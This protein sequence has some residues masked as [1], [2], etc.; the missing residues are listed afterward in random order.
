MNK[1]PDISSFQYDK[2]ANGHIESNVNMYRGAICFQYN[3][4]E[5]SKHE[6]V[7]ISINA[8]YNSDIDKS[9]TKCNV[10]APTGILGLGW[11]LTYEKIEC[12]KADLGKSPECRNYR[13]TTGDNSGSG[14][15]LHLTGEKNGLLYFENEIYD[16]SQ[17]IYDCGRE[18]WTITDQSGVKHLYGGEN[19]LQYAVVSNGRYTDAACVISL[20]QSRSIKSWNLSRV[21]SP[22]GFTVNYEYHFVE[23]SVTGSEL[24]YTKAAYIKKISDA[25]GNA[26]EFVY[27][28]KLW[29]V[30]KLEP[31]E[32]DDPHKMEPDDS[33]DFYQSE[34][35]TKYL[36][37]IMVSHSSDHIYCLKFGYELKNY[38][39]TAP[40]TGATA[41][42]MLTSIQMITKQRAMPA[43]QFEYCSQAEGNPGALKR[44]LYPEGGS[45]GYVYGKRQ[46]LNMSDRTHIVS[47]SGFSEAAKTFFGGDYAV[48]LQRNSGKMV[49]S[50]FQWIGRWQKY[51]PEVSFQGIDP[52]TA[53]VYPF[54]YY[55]VITCLTPDHRKTKYLVLTKWRKVKGGWQASAVETV[56]SPK[57]EIISGDKWF[58]VH[59]T[60][61]DTWNDYYYDE[62]K[63]LWE[64]GNFPEAEGK[65]GYSRFLTASGNRLLCF[66][67][68]EAG[69]GRKNII[70]IYERSPL[71]VWTMLAEMQTPSITLQGGG[72]GDCYLAFDGWFVAGAF[73]KDKTKKT[74]RYTLGVWRYNGDGTFGND[75]L[76]ELSLPVG[77]TSYI[78]PRISGNTVISSG[79]LYRFCGDEWIGCNKLAI[80]SSGSF[81][82]ALA[83]DIALA[84]SVTESTEKIS[85]AV[86]HKKRKIWETRTLFS[87]KTSE[88]PSYGVSISSNIAVCGS[89]VYDIGMHTFDKIIDKLNQDYGTT[90]LFNNGT[91]I[92]DSV[93][94]QSEDDKYMPYKTYI[95]TIENGK[96]V[97]KAFDSRVFDENC[98][99]SGNIFSLS[100]SGSDMKLLF[101]GGGCPDKPVTFYQ[102]TGVRLDDGIDMISRNYRY[103]ASSA[104]CDESGQYARYSK[105]EVMNGEWEEKNRTVYRYL[106]SISSVSASTNVVKSS[107]ADGT[108]VSVDSYLDGRLDNRL[109]AE[110][111]FADMVDGRK[112][113]GSVLLGGMLTQ[114][115]E[116]GETG[117]GISRIT[118]FK[119]D[120]LSGER[121]E[122]IT[123]NYNIKGEKEE[124]KSIT[125]FA[126]E[127]YPEMKEQHRLAEV[128]ESIRTVNGEIVSD[129]KTEYGDIDGIFSKKSLTLINPASGSN[130]ELYH[131]TDRGKY[132]VVTAKESI[133]PEY[134]IFDR[135]GCCRVAEF[136]NC[137]F[138]E[139][140]AYSFE[141]YEKPLY[142][143][144]SGAELTNTI[145]FAGS[146]CLEVQAGE[147]SNP[148]WHRFTS[149]G[150]AYGF[151]FHAQCERDCRL[152]VSAKGKT[153]EKR[154]EAGAFGYRLV[155]LREFAFAKGENTEITF[156]FVNDTDAPLF[157]DIVSFFP[158]LNPPHINVYYD[159]GV[160]L[161]AS[162]SGYGDITE[163]VY[164]EI[165]RTVYLIGNKKVMDAKLPSFLRET[166]DKVNSQFTLKNAGDGQYIR[167]IA[168]G[169][170]LRPSL[171]LTENFCVLFSCGGDMNIHIGRELRIKREGN[172]WTLDDMQ[173]G[174]YESLSCEGNLVAVLVSEIVVLAVNGRV[175]FSYCQSRK[176][177]ADFEM[178]ASA[179]IL[180]FV[181]GN[182]PTGGI[183]FS[184]GAGK[185]RQE[186]RLADGR[187]CVTAKS[188]DNMGREM[189]VTI[190]TYIEGSYFR[191]ISGYIEKMD[192]V[193]GKMSGIVSDKNQDCKGYPYYSRLYEERSGGRVIETGSPC[194]EYAVNYDIDRKQ[195]HTV[196][197]SYLN[198]KEVPYVASLNDLPPYY[199]AMLVCDPDNNR[200]LTVYDLQKNKVAVAVEVDGRWLLTTYYEEYQRGIRTVIVTLPKGNVKKYRYDFAGNLMDTSDVNSGEKKYF[201][202]DYNNLRFIREEV[203]DKSGLCK[204]RMYDA[205]QRLTEE[206]LCPSMPD[207]AL[208]KKA[209]EPSFPDSG[210]LIGKRYY[211]D[212]D[213]GINEIGTLTRI[214]IFD[215]TKQNLVVSTI[216]VLADKS[217][218]SVTK[219]I[220]M[221]SENYETEI[222]HD[223]FGN[224]T[225]ETGTDGIVTSYSYDCASRVKT[226]LRNG[227]ILSET[228]YR[229]DGLPDSVTSC[230]N[231]VH[232]EYDGR[233]KVVG[234]DS[235]FYTEKVVYLENGHYYNGKIKSVE[236]TIKSG[237]NTDG[238]ANIRYDLTYDESGRLLSAICEEHPEFSLKDIRYDR[239][240]NILSCDAGGTV[241]TFSLKDGT[242]Q[243]V[244]DGNAKY[245]YDGNGTVTHIAKGDEAAVGME[246][247]KYSGLLK[248]YTI[249][250]TKTKLLYDENNRRLGKIVSKNGKV[251]YSKT[252]LYDGVKLSEEIRDGK[253]LKYIHGKTGLNVVS[254]RGV[255]Y[256]VITDRLGYT[257]VVAECEK[258]IEAYHYKPF[259][260]AVKVIGDSELVKILFGNYELD[261][262]TGLYYAK[263]RIYDP[264]SYR[265]LSIDPEGEFPS[266][267]TFCGNDPFAVIDE[268]GERSWY[269]AL[270]GTV[271]G[272]VLTIGLSVLTMGAAAPVAT[273]IFGA[274]ATTITAASTAS[275]T[276]AIVAYNVAMTFAVTAISG[277]ASE[278]VKSLID[279]E[280]FTAA[281]VYDTLLSAAVAGLVFGGAGTLVGGVGKF[282]IGETE[283]GL[284]VAKKY[285]AQGAIL[286]LTNA[287]MS[288][289]VSPVSDVINGERVSGIGILE[290]GAF[291]ALSG[292]I[293]TFATA[294]AE[295]KT[296]NIK[297]DIVKET[298][299]DTIWAGFDPGVYYNVAME[300]A[301]SASAEHVY[302]EYSVGT[303]TYVQA[304]GTS[305]A[306]PLKS[307]QIVYEYACFGSYGENSG[308]SG[309]G[310]NNYPYQNI[311]SP[312]YF[313]TRGFGGKL[314]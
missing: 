118:S 129:E 97:G 302:D 121:R 278:G 70:K 261:S 115:S 31:R 104:A 22:G 81:Q 185:L 262:E 264:Y 24:T 5:L 267:Y 25:Y 120:P 109:T 276:A 127:D 173:N 186:H 205:L 252:Y 303:K 298:V 171:E 114:V 214:E 165:G 230:G 135:T 138:G 63:E 266:P 313:V 148:I 177:E 279:G 6:N 119:A 248:Q 235:P 295:S 188:Y 289:A 49:F 291:G 157:I 36:S 1:S 246:Y 285:V 14:A 55:C 194:P 183:T 73:V 147:C 167:R 56:N 92:A 155:D 15:P 10:E 66:A 132:G 94:R 133:F 137:G 190:P 82:F 34:Y 284:A 76:E 257:R 229:A 290:N 128:C 258:I 153:A 274:G 311:I 160:L 299:N 164:D 13:L 260:E 95:H 39:N 29:C 136:T 201:Y 232:Y 193:T 126:Y 213:Y 85:A 100:K 130:K 293:T 21:I 117:E 65:N 215:E 191:Y 158:L 281:C 226:V 59:D 48:V 144:A 211:Y 146:K 67:Y 37:E 225:G 145:C 180:N 151:S 74:L 64:A 79:Y 176:N 110:Y 77:E 306:I 72:D 197:T 282:A 123:Y 80:K 89:T 166:G 312:R 159:G 124:Q 17:I 140:F 259:G 30:N 116:M 219:T 272:I 57:V 263:S 143:P 222:C 42:R 187:V 210:K 44:T 26:A 103:D 139:C 255:D 228:K 216:S 170:N 189:A 256:S 206:G 93:Y 268:N 199:T 212:G 249:G 86:F 90:R 87:G 202:D 175:L 9:L 75:I 61:G 101:A 236:T 243:L 84:S 195:R 251:Q 288:A 107:V 69:G 99:G 71:A 149:S 3:L 46:D 28:D 50:V 16:G 88:I 238:P 51:T 154:I 27:G 203:C 152:L 41:K 19:N 265:F 224:I 52:G 40:V 297:K 198:L 142:I 307:E 45:A 292:M 106:D 12:E 280:P 209:L 242:D 2:A 309:F 150:I 96:V 182:E 273:A 181:I 169:K 204:Y 221:G 102:A 207:A 310:N 269:A 233:G 141:D 277:I 304:K 218:R 184:D 112:I 113:Y 287:G 275:Q 91:C 314:V 35:E 241:R 54:E 240:G 200:M 68:D 283:A 33:Y 301:D 58:F 108:L 192:P 231:T 47:N 11:R 245:E 178:T 60:V 308:K 163:P 217:R 208:A 296:L 53:K 83:E 179:E 250:E 7:G 161:A 300:A 286:G 234:I 239:N 156:V 78:A 125:R 196:R 23:Q 254:Y 220:T 4:V 223:N 131:I 271:I 32:Y 227:N 20:G 43:M 111:E 305:K 172:V 247:Y 162:L 134:F 62:P 174:I 270:I 38:A 8:A 253:T 294:V 122:L 237:E 18:I 105:V 168:A 244:S 98:G